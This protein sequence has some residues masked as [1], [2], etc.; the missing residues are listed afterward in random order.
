MPPKSNNIDLD[1]LQG[2][3]RFSLTWWS[4][5]ALEL[6]LFVMVYTI[7]NHRKS[8]NYLITFST[9]VWCM[10]EFIFNH[11]LMANLRKHSR[12]LILLL[13]LFFFFILAFFGAAFSTNLVVER[14]PFMI[15]K[16][17]DLFDSRGVNYYP[18]FRQDGLLYEAFERSESHLRQKIVH[19]CRQAGLDNCLLKDDFFSLV[20]VFLAY[21]TRPVVGILYD[22]VANVIASTLCRENIPTEDGKKTKPYIGKNSCGDELLFYRINLVNDSCKATKER[23]MSIL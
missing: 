21:K 15:D 9:N 19:K 2:F 11:N 22:I 12:L 18:A 23:L 13:S 1:I 8:T 17:E 6:M 4:L 10:I 16:L 7:L 3:G 20:E 5:I 14:K